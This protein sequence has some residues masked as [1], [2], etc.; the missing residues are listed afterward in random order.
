MR[1]SS[2]CCSLRLHLR[3]LNHVLQQTAR[4]TASREEGRKKRGG[5]HMH[6]DEKDEKGLPSFRLAS[7]DG[8]ELLVHPDGSLVGLR[9]PSHLHGSYTLGKQASYASKRSGESRPSPASS[10]A[11]GP[12]TFTCFCF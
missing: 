7:P 1:D 3:L 10:V 2:P 8:K 4:E 9:H 5:R 12:A 11:T 6:V